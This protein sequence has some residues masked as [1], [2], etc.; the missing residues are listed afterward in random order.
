VAAGRS[1]RDGRLR[2][3]RARPRR[4]GG[5]WRIGY[6]KGHFDRAIAA[7]AARRPLLTVGLAF[8]VQEVDSVPVEPHDRRLD[9]IVTEIE[10][11]IAADRG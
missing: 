8:S 9:R 6:G 2:R 3:A 4:A 1:A 11:I 5:L 10:V 7:L